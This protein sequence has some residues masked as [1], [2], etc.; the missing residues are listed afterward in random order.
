MTV[1]TYTCVRCGSSTAMK[2]LYPYVNGV[3]L[4]CW[5]CHS[6]LPSKS[7]PCPRCEGT[8]SIK[9]KSQESADR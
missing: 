3:G 9:V 7:V 2:D 8:G 1:I 4:V 6:K 5:E